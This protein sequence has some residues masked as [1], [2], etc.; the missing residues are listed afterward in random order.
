[1]PKPLRFQSELSQHAAV[2]AFMGLLLVLATALAYAT[3]RVPAVAVEVDGLSFVL[4]SSWSEE[5]AQQKVQ[6]GDVAVFADARRPSLTLSVWS[7]SLPEQSGGG[8]VEPAA[9]LRGKLFA[10]MTGAEIQIETREVAGLSV[11]TWVGVSQIRL[12]YMKPQV[13]LHA[14]AMVAD[15]AGRYWLLTLGDRKFSGEGME[16]RVRSHTALFEEVLGTLKRVDG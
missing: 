3:V 13:G 2:A 6:V 5:A 10:F 12:P 7:F 14:M 9:L 8:Y 1:M 15:G 16:K 4:P 11:A